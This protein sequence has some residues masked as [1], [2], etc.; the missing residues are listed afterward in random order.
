[1]SLL[2]SRSSIVRDSN[3][4]DEPQTGSF[5]HVTAHDWG[6]LII[7]EHEAYCTW[8]FLYDHGPRDLANILQTDYITGAPS[9]KRRHLYR[10]LVYHASWQ[11]R[12][13]DSASFPTSLPRK[14]LRFFPHTLNEQ[15]QSKVEHLK[16]N[17]GLTG[18]IPRPGQWNVFSRF[19]TN[20]LPTD[21]RVAAAGI[22]PT[23]RNP[24]RP[25][26]CFFCNDGK[27]DVRHIFG[28]C[29]PIRTT[30][31]ATARTMGI[32]LPRQVATMDIVTLTTAGPSPAFPLYP[33]FIITFVW[34]VWSDRVRF[35]SL[36]S[37]LR[38][39]PSPSTITERLET[40]TCTHLP[41][42]SCKRTT[43]EA[44]IALANNPPPEALV[45]FADGSAIPNP[46]PCG[47]G[48]L[49]MVPDETGEAISTISLG[50]GDN[51]LGEIA[52]LLK[53]LR[54]V[55]EAYTRGLVTGHP[56]LILFT[57]SLLVVGAL[58]WGWSTRNMPPLI[59]NLSR[60]FRERKADNPVALYWVKGHSQIIYNEVVD[61]RAKVGAAW[62]KAGIIC[63]RTKWT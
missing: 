56:A 52:G 53:I 17:L 6:T 57:D 41:Q 43:P 47:A 24:L 16:T 39:P 4:Y 38:Q 9:T 3:G 20:A 19:I 54:L 8:L 55:D 35:F 50:L 22:F 14:R 26:A 37:T 36:F 28:D 60:A 27:D 48:A 13:M 29:G 62:S 21:R 2:A 46:G 40:Y 42:P 12:D 59:R 30:L 49:L 33:V 63:R 32:N 31:H 11:K 10:Q 15:I 18:T 7:A 51:N 23:N 58:E 44:V 5:A 25:Q 34:A 45:G 1:M 61:K